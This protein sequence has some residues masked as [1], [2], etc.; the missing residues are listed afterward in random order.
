MLKSSRLM[1]ISKF[2]KMKNNVSAALY[3][4][5]KLKKNEYVRRRIQMH[6]TCKCVNFMNENLNFI[7]RDKLQCKQCE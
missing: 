3:Q 2:M 6:A 7:L 5:K 4:S 1:K